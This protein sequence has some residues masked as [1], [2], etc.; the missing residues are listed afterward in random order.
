M[1][2]HSPT[3]K[4]RRR[5]PRRPGID[6]HSASEFA[7]RLGIGR[8]TVWRLMKTGR[9]RFFRVSPHIVRIPVSEYARLSYQPRRRRTEAS[10]LKGPEAA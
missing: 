4:R 8:T 3:G 7:R 6:F 2:K 10:S 1:N 9:L 5:A